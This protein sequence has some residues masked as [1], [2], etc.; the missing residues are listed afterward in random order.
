M[1]NKDKVVM[2]AGTSAGETF[3]TNVK[4]FKK[5]IS[6]RLCVWKGAVSRYVM[7]LDI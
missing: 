2:M 1:V 4:M 7:C 5:E 3:F 6:K